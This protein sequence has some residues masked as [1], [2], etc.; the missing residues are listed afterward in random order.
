MDA[1]DYL[2]SVSK[3]MQNALDA[4]ILSQKQFNE[5]FTSM[6]KYL[7][8]MHAVHAHPCCHTYDG[9]T[10]QKNYQ[11]P[12]FKECETNCYETK[13]YPDESPSPVNLL[14]REVSL[15]VDCDNNG[16]IFTEDFLFNK[17]DLSVP[18]ILISMQR[19]KVIDKTISILT[20]DEY[21]SSVSPYAFV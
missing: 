12:F 17:E 2:A 13:F 15:M 16:K 5:S 6:H 14:M 19:L 8:H 10:D 4:Y 3:M 9:Q 7:V 21:L 20:W 18:K 11:N 1:I